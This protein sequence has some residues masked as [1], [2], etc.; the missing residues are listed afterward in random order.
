MKRYTASALLLLFLHFAFLPSSAQAQPSAPGRGGQQNLC[1]VKLKLVD[2]TSGEAVEF[3]TVSMTRQGSDKVYKYVLSDNKGVARFSDVRSGK[4][5]IKGELLGYEPCTRQIEVGSKNVDLGKVEMKVQA[6]FLEGAVVTDVGNQ[7]VVKGDTVEHNVAMMNIT[8]NEVLEDVLKRLP[9]I[10]VEDGKIMANGKQIK[11]ITVDGKT[12]FLDDPQLASKNLP[13]KIIEK[14]KVIEKKSEQA[15]FTGIDDGEEETVI[16]LSIQ[17][18]MNNGWFGNLMAGGG[19]DLKGL[20]DDGNK[21]GNDPRYQGAAMVARFSNASQVAFLGNINNTNNRGFEDVSGSMMANLRGNT[22]RSSG[23]GITTSYMAGITAGKVFDDKSELTGNYIFSG[24]ENVQDQLSA[25]TTFRK[26]DNLYTVN[27]NSDVTDS[28]SHKVGVRADWKIS[29]QTSILFEPSFTY[30]WGSFSESQDFSSESIGASSRSKVNDGYS[31]S[32]GDNDNLSTSGRLLWRQRLGKPGRT[33]SINMNYSF[34]DNSMN[35]LNQ[36]ETDKYLDGALSSVDIVD[37]WYKRDSRSSRIGG[38]ISYTEPL[39]HNFY[40]EA[41]Y[42]YNRNKSVSDKNTYDKDGTGNYTVLDQTYSNHIENISISQRA[43]VNFLKQEQKYKATVGVSMQP[44]RTINHTTGSKARDIDRSVCNWSPNARLDINFSRNEVL[45]FRYNGNTSQPSISQLQPVPD[46]SNPQRVKLGNPDLDPSF[47]HD[48]NASY[49]KSNRQTFSSINASADFTYR[50]KNIVNAS[51]YDRGGVQ[52]TIPVNNNRGQYSASLRLTYNTPIAK[53]K[54]SVMTSLNSSMSK[55]VSYVGK[56]NIDI[57]DSASY[58]NLD[59]YTE[60]ATTNLSV[61]GQ[62]RLTY[63]TDIVECQVGGNSR[64]SQ[65][66]YSMSDTSRTP[67]WTN[68]ING[69]FVARIPKVFT[70]STDARYTF[71]AGYTSGYNEPALVW[72]AEISKQL[73][74]NNFTIAVKAY[75]LLNQ[76]KSTSRTTNENYIRDVRNN[77]LGRYIMASLTYRFGT[78]GNRRGGRM[79]MG[80]GR[81]P[82]GFGGGGG[83]Y[84]GGGRRM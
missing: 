34:S 83:M 7:I 23:T 35:G 33:M 44:S 28:Y 52:Y 54:F 49:R 26:S 59:N 24:S 77:T 3:A 74:R 64:F 12:F 36:S 76:S 47:S 68:R 2:A 48:F 70:I 4:Y 62:L 60:N 25:K 38:R 79:P 43:G 55:G 17:K 41:T 82:G 69:R 45:R 39:G 16:D 57:E 66:W 73:F 10:E 75:D 65:A 51:W 37:Q 72:N 40:A 20:D 58:L 78:F 18:G 5:E 53:S 9:G 11:K 8:D 61:N 6:T 42:S 1:E 63:R 32:T 56:D 22:N 29:K 14:V 67:T 19:T 81:M 27:K 46:N 21:V 50:N 13:A 15:E 71:Y 80:G 84:S 31:L 30:G